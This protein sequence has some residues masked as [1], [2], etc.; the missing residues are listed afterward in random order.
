MRYNA[1]TDQNQAEIVAALRAVGA[2]VHPIHRLGGGLP[3]LLVGYRGQNYLLEVKTATGHLTPDEAKFF[4]T[5]RGQVA[6]VRNITQAL[7]AIDITKSN[8]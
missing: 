1:K 8:P 4:Q 5:W 3:D 2:T 6:I 7:A